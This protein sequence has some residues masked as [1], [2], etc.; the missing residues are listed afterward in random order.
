MTMPAGGHAFVVPAYGDS[1]HLAECLAS[2]R[3]QT[4]PADQ[5][6]LCTSTPSEYLQDVA[7]RF[8]LPLIE[9]GAAPSIAGDWNFA[10]SRAQTRLVT[11][12][13][14]D[15]LYEPDYARA[16][17]AHWAA[18][19]QT[20]IAFTDYH[21]CTD[22]GPR[23]DPINLRIKRML[24]AQAFRGEPVIADRAAKRRLVRWGNPVCCPSVTF[25]RERLPD[26]KFASGFRTNLDWDAWA[27]LAET[28]AQFGYLAQKLVR[29]RVHEKSETT[30]TLASGHRERED[31][32]LFSRF[33]PAPMVSLLMLAYRQ[34][35]RANKS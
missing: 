8:E 1:P 21:E 34:S 22:H 5:V 29:K 33:W 26:F 20:A 12:A 17:R 6:V 11:I 7:R 24:C 28:D 9:T 25:D 32:E 35:Y 14:Q 3:A 23:P 15:D 10:L 13:H 4:Q 18:H 30:E 27:R 2:I 31:R 19:P 16:M